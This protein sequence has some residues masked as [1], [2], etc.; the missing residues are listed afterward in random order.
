MGRNWKH[1][2]QLEGTEDGSAA[3]GNSREASQRRINKT[4]IGSSNSTS[5]RRSRRLENRIS[6]R[7]VHTWVGGSTIHKSQLFTA[8][9][10]SNGRGM[11]KQ[12]VMFIH[13]GILF[14][15]KKGKTF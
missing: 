3:V 12:T 15:L 10:L 7:Y 5:G 2:A 8:T 13:N 11:D 1:W 14:S 9:Q 6:K 4:A